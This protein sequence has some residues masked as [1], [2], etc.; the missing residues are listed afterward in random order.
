MAPVQLRNAVFD[1]ISRINNNDDYFPRESF[2]SYLEFLKYFRAI[3]ILY[4]N[5]VD[6][7]LK[8]IKN[9]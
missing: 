9:S 6:I 2:D 5:F 8:K 7:T 1:L 3:I 4:H